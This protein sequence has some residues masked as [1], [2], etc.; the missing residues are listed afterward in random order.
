MSGLFS[1]FN[2]AKR[3]MNVQQKSIDV[4]SHNIANSNT[5]GYSRQRAKIETSRPFGGASRGSSVG[6]GQ[7][8]T[9]SQ[10]QAIERVRDN[11][12]DYQVRGENAVLGK[13]D[14]RNNYLYEVESVFN[15]PSETGLS[16]LM[17]KFFDSFQE[18]SKQPNSS[19]ARTVVAQQSAALAD[20]LNATYTKLEGLQTN[21]QDMLKSSV[22][23]VNS[24]LEQLDRVNQEIISVT[25]SGNAPN[26]LMD[27]RDLLLDQLSYKFGIQVDKKEFNG[28]D[29]KPTSSGKMKADLLVN[30]SPNGDV[31]R[32]SYVTDVKLDESDLSGKTYIVTYYKN[33]NMDSEANKQTLK[34]SGITLEQAK[35]IKD[36]RVIW[37]DSNGQAVRGDGYPIRDG[38]TIGYSELMMFKPE[39]GSVSG[40]ISVQKDI[41]DYMNQLNK[42]AKALA[43]SVNAVHSGIEDPLNNTGDVDKDYLPFFVNKDVASYRSNG[44]LSNLDFTLKAEEEITAKN[45]SINKEI[46]EDVMKIKTKT[47]DDLYKYTNE[48]IMDGDSDGARALAIAKLRDSLIRIQDINETVKSRS[49]MFNKNKGGNSLS[50]NGLNVESSTSGMKIDSYFKDTI[51]R[52]GVQAQEAQRM[53][54][55][56]EDLLYSI[57]ESRASVSGVSL[58]EEMANLVQF[59][60][61][62][63]ANAK[64]IA[65]VDELLEVIINGLKR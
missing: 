10:I 17:G 52:L 22:T 6:A 1:T 5:V 2:I 31:S 57:E 59:Q 29:V 11:F 58:D 14:M 24:M 42:L 8:G 21:A 9:G 53:V 32:F 63:N 46:L 35:E 54:T 40:I 4:T 44:T 33:G 25:V 38:D 39:T 51:D 62:Y 48:N 7:L 18:L 55:N 36:S 15:E 26:D 20:A 23:E 61:A 49:D 50:N 47:H 27:K 65:T 56:Q 43:F 19:N 28:V 41:E 60:H 37:A 13:Y 16:T 3:G 45:I 34:V 64:I 12:L 30:S